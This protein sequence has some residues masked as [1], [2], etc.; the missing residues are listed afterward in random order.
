MRQIET[1]VRE[2][3]QDEPGLCMRLARSFL[4]HYPLNTPRISVLRRLP[5]V[6]E[7]CCPFVAKGG[8]RICACHAGSRDVISKSLYWLGDFDPWVVALLKKLAKPR[9]IALDVGANI[10]AISLRLS[11]FVGPK[12]KV[13]SFEPF[14]PNLQLLRKNIAGNNCANVE[15]VGIALSSRSGCCRVGTP[16]N[17]PGHAAIIEEE[18]TVDGAEA[19]RETLDDL[20]EQRRI[21][22][23]SVCKIDVEGHERD[24]F[25]GARLAIER[26][27]IESF[28]FERQV[29]VD[30]T[31]DA[32]FQLLRTNGYRLWRVWKHCVGL[33]LAEPGSR[34]SAGSTDDF[35]AVSVGSESE[36]LMVDYSHRA[37]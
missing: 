3:V 8:I 12:G 19:R 16:D 34:L 27:T 26:R 13:I 10:G 36:Q 31:E 14:P 18:S 22:K 28:V 9:S 32:V 4:R 6:P 29:A 17:Q 11:R 21:A 2:P 5:G 37:K 7:K 15:I 20:M 25:D 30:T 24:V 23:V 35:V 33:S 1:R